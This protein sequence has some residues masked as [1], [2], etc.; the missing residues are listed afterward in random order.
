MPSTGHRRLG[1]AGSGTPSRRT[2]IWALSDPILFPLPY[3]CI[4]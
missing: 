1:E 3:E 4:A 2:R